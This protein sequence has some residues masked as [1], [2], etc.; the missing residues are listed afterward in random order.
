[1]TTKSNEP[2]P[3]LLPLLYFGLAHVALTLAFAVVAVN[4]AG[5]TG[6]FYHPRML[7]VV[8]LVTIG[9]ITASILG[10]LYLVGP[11]ALRMPL[12]ARW[13]D[14]V[15]AALVAIG[16]VGI[17]S[18][19]WIV[20]Y[21]GMSWSGGTA[22]AGVLLVGARLIGPLRRAAVPT[23]VKLHVALAFGN[24]IGAGTMGILLA[25]HKVHPFLPGFPLD[26][27]FAHAHLAAVGWASM[28]VMGIAYRLLPMV[29]PSRMPTGS[30]L[31][32]SAILLE[33]GVAGLFLT[34]LMHAP[35]AG[36]FALV[37][38][39]GFAVFFTQAGWM[40]R[41]RR[42]RPPAIRTP[43]FSV[44]HAVS[45]LASLAVACGLGLW[46][47]FA[48]PSR[49]T[50]PVA[51]AYGVLGLVGFLAQMVVAMEGRLLPLLAWYW[52]SANADGRGSV[53]S[54]H[55]MPWRAA[56][57]AVFTSWLAGVPALAAGLALGS[58]AVTGAAAWLLCAAMLLQSA[59]GIH[60][61]RYAYAAPP[62]HAGARCSRPGQRRL[63]NAA[64]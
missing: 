43:D 53:P 27:V 17:V 18:H 10:A 48:E 64:S 59:Q 49:F 51:T 31:Y 25:I 12:R 2:P 16:L 63:R 22:A 7:A 38:V 30:R 24:M 52:A 44:V 41:H 39:A 28:M 4:P 8:H 36:I 42:P 11:I 3:R 6:F 58:P 20:E 46:L 47:S 1:V 19:F 32:G 54:P 50:I 9:W 13:F 5:V 61:L 21:K 57:I 33:I 35:G 14:Y 60:V 55:E 40:L 37:I 26:H 29:L 15:A 62:R 34:L 56:H 23:A 45:A